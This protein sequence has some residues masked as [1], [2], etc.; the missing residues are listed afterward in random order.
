MFETSAGPTTW[1][2]TSLPFPLT[3]LVGRQRELDAAIGLLQRPDLRLLTLTGPGGVGK[4]RLSLAIGTAIEEMGYPVAFVNLAP[5]ADPTLVLPEI[6]SAI[7][8]SAGD[9]VTLMSRIVQTIGYQRLLF[10]IDNFEQVVA[11]SVHLSTLLSLCPG[12][13]AL[14][15]SRMPLHIQGEQ[16]L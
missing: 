12:T 16:E 2:L 3:S 6:A 11:A 7:G 1:T 9:K 5:I 8:V 4:T 15:T 13:K 10:V 14:V